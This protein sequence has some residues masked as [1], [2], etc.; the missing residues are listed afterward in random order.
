MRLSASL[1]LISLVS[2][3]NASAG[4]DRWTTGGPW[5]GIVRA[6]AVD[7]QRTDTVYAASMRGTFRTTD[8]GASWS[9]TVSSPPDPILAL[10]I[11]PSE[12]EI[13]YAGIEYQ[14]VFKTPDGGVTWSKTGDLGTVSRLIVD[15]RNPRIV[16]AGTD[17]GVYKSEDGADSWTRVLDADAGPGLT[18]DPASSAV[19]YAGAQ[20][21]SG[22]IFRTQDGGAT[23]ANLEVPTAFSISSIG[24]DPS[25]SAVLYAGTGG[26][27]L[28]QSVDGG[29]TW[30][31][32]DLG[33]PTLYIDSIDVGSQSP[34]S[35][36]VATDVGVYTSQD[37]GT[38]WTNTGPPQPPGHFF[39]LYTFAAGPDGVWYVGRED[40]VDKSVD[41]GASWTA[42]NVG[43]GQASVPSLAID[44]FQPSTVYAGSVDAPYLFQSSDGGASWNGYVGDSIGPVHAVA[45]D[46]SEPG[47]LYAGGDGGVWRSADRG[48][49]WN[50][51][52]PSGPDGP[53]TVLSVAIEPQR[54]Q[55]L[56]AGLSCCDFFFPLGLFKSSDGG[57]TWVQDGLDDLASINALALRPDAAVL[58]VGASAG[59]FGRGA[60]LFRSTDD[61]L[62]WSPTSVTS[63]IASPL[64]EPRTLAVYAGSSAGG[65]WRSADDGVTWS[66]IGSGLPNTGVLAIVSDPSRAGVL[67]VGTDGAGVYASSDDGESWTPLNEGLGDLHVQSLALDSTGTLHAGTVSRGVFDRRIPAPRDVVRRPPPAR[68]TRVLETR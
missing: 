19:L 29:G 49:D 47:L 1:A 43:L 28:F 16:W 39:G 56:F 34:G 51:L 45:F 40:G 17:A 3:T 8:G 37:G 30:V 38:H 55:T 67:Y 65:L 5:G 60:G 25:S 23:W 27:G 57:A 33:R 42:I 21:Q 53:G 54:P 61:G 14:G 6:F 22:R 2:S 35:L 31:Q 15:P 44:P 20:G 59:R 46:P 7:P 41:A 12:P 9:P 62:S 10:A 64:V 66:P 58:Y 36:L 18:M 11:D 48:L 4:V 63:P 68:P 13:L 52:L 24:A 26:A 32:L 50:Q